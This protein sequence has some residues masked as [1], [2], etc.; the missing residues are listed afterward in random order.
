[1]VVPERVASDADFGTTSPAS[2]K[3]VR[4]QSR[5]P[6]DGDSISLFV[7]FSRPQ[8][9]LYP[10]LSAL[11]L[12]RCDHTGARPSFGSRE[13][14]RSATQEGSSEPDHARDI[15]LHACPSLTCAAI[16]SYIA[17]RQEPPMLSRA[18]VTW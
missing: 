5:G 14:H 1:M 9:C 16:A 15:R 11:C 2:R 6:V 12:R 3:A 17:V 8:R 13:H 18:D 4:R 10:S 7:L